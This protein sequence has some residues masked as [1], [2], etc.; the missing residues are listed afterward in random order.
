EAALLFRL[1]PEIRFPDPEALRRQIAKDREE[2]EAL[3]A[4]TAARRGP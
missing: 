2:A 3:L 1:R 4:E